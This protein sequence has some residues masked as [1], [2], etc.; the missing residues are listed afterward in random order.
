MST[1]LTEANTATIRI[2]DTKGGKALIEKI[3]E[4]A[5]EPGVH[6]TRERGTT[7]LAFHTN[8]PG[9]TV[10][11]VRGAD[12]SQREFKLASKDGAVRITIDCDFVGSVPLPAANTGRFI[13]ASDLGTKLIE[14]AFSL[15][16]TYAEVVDRDLEN[17]ARIAKFKADVAAGRITVRTPE[18]IAED[19]SIARDAEIVRANEGREV[20]EYDGPHAVLVLAARRRHALRQRPAPAP[21]PDMVT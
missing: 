21:H 19:T 20:F 10:P 16:L 4:L 6:V 11:A 8:K 2:H 3:I 15:D 13:T 12:H 9:W 5:G 14:A 1:S 17:E 18:Q 7:T